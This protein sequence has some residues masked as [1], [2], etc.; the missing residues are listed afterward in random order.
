MGAGGGRGE[1]VGGVL[2]LQL[3]LNNSKRGV[4][5]LQSNLN[6]SNIDGSF[7]LANFT[8]ESLRN[9]SDSSRKQ[10][11]REFSYFIMKLYDVCTH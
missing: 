1:S 8:L 3:N 9:S 6:N 5:K 4:L 7:I 10:I 11:F 2:K